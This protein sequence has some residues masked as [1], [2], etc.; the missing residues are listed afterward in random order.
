M[1]AQQISVKIA[2]SWHGEKQITPDYIDKALADDKL[3]KW[4][5]MRFIDALYTNQDDFYRIER[6][7]EERKGKILDNKRKNYTGIEKISLL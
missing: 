3:E 4:L 2:N 1:V 5:S 7:S 6:A